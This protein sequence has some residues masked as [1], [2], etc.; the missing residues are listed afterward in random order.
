MLDLDGFKAINDQ[1]GHAAGDEILRR[2]AAIIRSN[3]RDAD[4]AARL[5]GEEFCLILR[6]LDPAGAYA[7]A[8]RIRGALEAT[9]ALAPDHGAPTV[10]A[11]IAIGSVL[12]DTFDRLL[13][14]AD[15][16][17]YRAKGAGRNRVFGPS[18]RLA[19]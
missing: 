2:F 8:E 10:S 11:G 3:I 12:G 18:R 13:R 4:T 16:R 9:S 7:V 14:E 1:F 5:G 17:L 19:A 15:E 6:G